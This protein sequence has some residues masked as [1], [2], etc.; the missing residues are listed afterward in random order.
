MKIK[1]IL[2]PKCKPLYLEEMRRKGRQGM[3]NRWK[4]WNETKKKIAKESKRNIKVEG[5]KNMI[6]S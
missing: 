6:K 1:D 4:N 2:C 3:K 5:I